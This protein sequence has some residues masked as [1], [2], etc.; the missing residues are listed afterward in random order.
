MSLI[1]NLDSVSFNKFHKRLFETK[2]QKEDFKMALTAKPNAAPSGAPAPAPAP[3]PAGATT[4]IAKTEVAE[5]NTRFKAMGTAERAKMTEDQ[6]QMEGSS[7]D[8]IEFVAA[9]GNPLKKQ[10]RREGKFDVPSHEVVGYKFKALDNIQVPVAKMKEGSDDLFNVED[11]GWV[12]V[13]KGA[14]FDVTVLE[15]V[16]LLSQIEYAGRAT[17]GGNVV[18]LSAKASQTR[19][20]SLPILVATTGSVKEGM[21][22]VGEVIETP[23]GAKTGKVLE[24]YADKFGVLFKR[25]SAGKKASAQAKKAGDNAADIAA[26]FRLTLQKKGLA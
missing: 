9:L 4:A 23:D 19:E 7:S 10:K 15:N 16:M 22:L 20:Y 26:A 11:P 5:K 13:K 12:P 6:K 18:S 24:Q 2:K 17:G 25:R 21:R 8:K 3:A 14:E 1:E